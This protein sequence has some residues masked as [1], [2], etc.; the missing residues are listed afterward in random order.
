MQCDEIKSR[1]NDWETDQFLPRKDLQQCQQHD[2]ILQVFKQIG[3]RQRWYSLQNKQT[4]QIIL[5]HVV[6]GKHFFNC[7]CNKHFSW[8]CDYNVCLRKPH[9]SMAQRRLSQILWNA[10]SKD[11]TF[12]SSWSEHET[13]KQEVFPNFPYCHWVDNKAKVG[14]WLT[15]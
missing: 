2:P 9:M 3:H 5:F 10:K 8:I 15:I 12:S 14:L 7:I 13:T 6:K 1:I 4:P 11:L